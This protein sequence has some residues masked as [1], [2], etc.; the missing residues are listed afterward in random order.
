MKFASIAILRISYSV[1][2]EIVEKLSA[3]QYSSWPTKREAVLIILF[4][5]S[6]EIL[7]ESRVR[8]QH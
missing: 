4:Y 3:L 1:F 2:A 6:W 8:A 7:G 5:P